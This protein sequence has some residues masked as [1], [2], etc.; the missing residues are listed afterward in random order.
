MD[1]ED[2]AKCG[3]RDAAL[4]DVWLFG[5]QE[6]VET[7]DRSGERSEGRGGSA[8]GE[9]TEEPI[10]RNRREYSG[11]KADLLAAMCAVPRG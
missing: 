4:C 1:S 11:R 6:T 3:R 9:K 10:S 8:R 2:L 7:R 5:K